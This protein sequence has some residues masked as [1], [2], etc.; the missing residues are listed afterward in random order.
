LIDVLYMSIEKYRPPLFH[1]LSVNIEIVA[2]YLL[3]L[4]IPLYKLASSLMTRIRNTHRL[5]RYWWKV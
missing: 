2:L 5:P 1:T 4:T 3:Y